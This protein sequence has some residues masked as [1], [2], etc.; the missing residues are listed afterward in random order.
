MQKATNLSSQQI[1]NTFERLGLKELLD[2]SP[3]VPYNAFPQS[4][5]QGQIL[6]PVLSDS[7]VPPVTAGRIDKDAH[8]EKHP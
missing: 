8:M 7:C 6:I 4:E 5:N 2:P 1:D 3:Y